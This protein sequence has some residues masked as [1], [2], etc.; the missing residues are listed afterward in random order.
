M[1]GVLNWKKGFFQNKKCVGKVVTMPSF[2]MN[3]NFLA[4]A[5]SWTKLIQLI[6]L[7]AMK[8]HLKKMLRPPK[9]HSSPAGRMQECQ[10]RL[11]ILVQDIN[12]GFDILQFENQSQKADNDMPCP[13]LLMQSIPDSWTKEGCKSRASA[14]CSAVLI[15]DLIMSDTKPSVSAPEELPETWHSWGDRNRWANQAAMVN[16]KNQWGPFTGQQLFDAFLHG[17]KKFFFH[18]N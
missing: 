10:F 8:T 3:S 11:A 15:G 7:I 14:G 13:V 18:K 6:K 4:R 12:L 9:T 1:V 2:Q 5:E 17:K 16:K